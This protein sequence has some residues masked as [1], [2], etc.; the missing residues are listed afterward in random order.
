MKQLTKLM[1]RLGCLLALASTVPAQTITGTIT[2]T[3]TDP[4]GAVVPKVKVTATNTGT[5]ITNTRNQRLWPFQPPLPLRR[6]L[7]A[8]G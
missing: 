1:L 2:G 6:R 7:F 3:V 8:H 5:N 4:T